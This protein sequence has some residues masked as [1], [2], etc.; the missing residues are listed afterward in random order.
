V[1]W[2]SGGH[3]AM[4]VLTTSYGVEAKTFTGYYENTDIAKKLKSL[5]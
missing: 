2:T 5:L 4:P 1:G 3:T